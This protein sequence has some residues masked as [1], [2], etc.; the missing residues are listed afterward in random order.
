MNAKEAT[1]EKEVS[2][3]LEMYGKLR[4]QII[5]GRTNLKSQLVQMKEIIEEKTRELESLKHQK[6]K[7]EGAIEV[8]EL[9]LK[10]PLPSNNPKA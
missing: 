2:P 5:E 9:Y 6:A 10:D 7:L 8:S 4:N 1:K 3:D